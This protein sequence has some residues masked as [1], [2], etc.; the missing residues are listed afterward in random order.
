MTRKDTILIAVVINAGLLAI[1]FT[2]AVIY[3]TDKVEQTEFVTPASDNRTIQTEPPPTLIAAASSTGDEVDNVLKYFSQPSSPTIVMEAQSETY[4][5]EPIAIQS[6]EE[7][8][9]DLGQE[10]EAEQERFVE[11]KVKKGDMLEKIAKANKTT[12]GAIKRANNLQN[13]RLSIGQVLKIPVNQDSL[14]LSNQTASK[15]K[16]ETKE[17]PKQQ[18]KKQTESTEAVY[19]VIKSGDNPW[20]IAKQFNVKYD[21]ILRLNHIDEEKARNLK[22]GD[23]IRVK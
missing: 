9:E 22:I 1:L 20:K 4:A 13:E 16:Q 11:V 10:L 2:T 18:T 8:G 19:Y 23:R 14:A 12:V 6:N 5:P 17:E 15:K 7:D 3:D 21:D